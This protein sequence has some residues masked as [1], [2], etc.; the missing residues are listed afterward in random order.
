[1]RPSRGQVLGT[2]GAVALLAALMAVGRLDAP[3]RPRR[4]A[5]PAPA[6]TTATPPTPPT[7]DTT[8]RPPTPPRL[9]GVPLAGTGVAAL[10]IPE[11]SPSAVPG[12]FWL[13]NGQLTPIGGLPHGGCY[14]NPT[15]LPHPRRLRRLA[16][17]GQRVAAAH[18]RRAGPSRHQPVRPVEPPQRPGAAPLR[19][20]AGRD[21]D[22][23]RLGRGRVR[24]AAL[25]AAPQRP[26]RRH[27]HPGGRPAGRLGQ[28]WRV[29][30]RR[31]LPGGGLQR[32]R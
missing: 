24:P 13:D 29:Q 28:H 12:L 18:P 17:Y 26:G 16:G 14:L 30:P 15:P 19:S 7:T 25:P 21:G 23:D 11:A 3:G 4:A 22:H 27:R 1:M 10:L 6:S 20:G 2:L 5:A 31:P 8:V 9:R 32:R